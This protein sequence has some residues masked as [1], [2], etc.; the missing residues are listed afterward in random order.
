M[1]SYWYDITDKEK[2]SQEKLQ[3]LSNELYSIYL[4]DVIV[5]RDDEL[6]SIYS[7]DYIF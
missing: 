1:E 4:D 3:R 5:K 7:F 2:V 6:Y